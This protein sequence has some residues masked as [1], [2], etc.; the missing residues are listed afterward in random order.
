[1]G[2]KKKHAPNERRGE[3]SRKKELNEMEASKLPDTELKTM[4][5][6]MLKELSENFNSMENEMKPIKKNQQKGRTQYLK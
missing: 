6:R 2:R 4:V 1:M 3:I 5:I